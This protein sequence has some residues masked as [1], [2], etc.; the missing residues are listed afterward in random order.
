MAR[1]KSRRPL[2][3]GTFPRTL[4]VEQRRM[5][6]APPLEL[7]FDPAETE[8]AWPAPNQE[9]PPP[10]RAGGLGTPWPRRRQA[11]TT[12]RTRPQ[13]GAG[14]DPVSDPPPSGPCRKWP[15]MAHFSGRGGG[16]ILL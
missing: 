2:L 8:G 10:P 9:L 15:K 5:L 14:N 1:F 6:T 4:T 16:T 12:E 13:K 3:G 7:P 11:D